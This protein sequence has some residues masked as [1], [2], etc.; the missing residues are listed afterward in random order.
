ML[1]TPVTIGV[2]DGSGI[3]WQRNDLGL[4]MGVEEVSNS[5][6]KIL[7]FDEEFRSRRRTLSLLSGRAEVP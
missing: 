6:V 7:V 3:L 2:F 4:V 5:A 1:A